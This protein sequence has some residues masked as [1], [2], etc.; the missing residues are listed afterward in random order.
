VPK[1]VVIA[2][3]GTGGHIFPAEGL[4]RD[5]LS[6][7][8]EVVFIGGGLSK[9]RYFRRDEFRYEEV[10]SSVLKGLGSL[11]TIGRGIAESL[12]LLREIAPDLIVGFGSFYTFPVLVAAQMRRRPIVLFEPNAIPGKVNRLFSRFAQF[13]AVQFPLAR[14]GMRG[15]V[16]VVDV[17]RG[18]GGLV[19]PARA[20]DYFYLRPHRPTILIFGGS[21]GSE[22]INRAVARATQGLAREGEEFQVIHIAGTSASAQALRDHYQK[23]GIPSCVKA[24]EEKMDLAW[25]AADLV[26]CRSG[27]VSVAE[28]IGFSV[29]A[30]FIPFPRAADNHQMANAQFVESLGGAVV[31]PEKH[32]SADG[33]QREIRRLLQ[34]ELPEMRRRLT[35]FQKGREAKSLSRALAEFL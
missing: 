35:E 4:G 2:T 9:N 7:G 14:Q 25:S 28:Q 34:G 11:W 15:D 22:A 18:R 20:R 19:D 30:I 8:V 29:P 23:M 31:M 26:I 32:L 13:S 16:R 3:G 5:L 1:K 21:Q 10:P 17:P 6:Q 12:R 33:L 24:F 27:A